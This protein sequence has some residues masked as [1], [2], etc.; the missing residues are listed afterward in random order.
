MNND[1]RVILW[2]RA[3][4]AVTW[5]DDRE[6][7]V[8]Q[9]TPEFLNSGIQLAPLMMPLAEFP[10]EF[11]ALARGTF[12]GL[13]GLLA[14]SLPDR[15]GNALID[16]WLA[17]QGR[18]PGS[19]HPVERLCYVGHRGMGALEFEPA[20]LGPPSSTS[21]IDLAN[22]VELVNRVLDER[23][24][25]SGVLAGE[26]DGKAMQDILRVGTSAGGAR[27]KAILAWNPETGEFR[28]GQIDAAAGFEHWLL[29]FD[30]ISNNRDKEL[31]DPKG[32]GKIEY[33]YHLMAVEAGIHM[34]P[35]R[36]LH[37][38]GRSHFMTKRFDRTADGGKRHLQSLGAIAHVDFNHAGA[39][40]YE[41]AIQVMRQLSLPREDLEQQVLRAVFNVV[42][43]NQDDHV[44][45][46]AFL[47]NRRG[48]WRLS[49]AFDITYAYN[50]AGAWTNRH[51][52]SIHGKWVDMDREDLIALAS[53]AGIKQA[54]ANEMI[55]RVIAVMR[56]WPDFALK[57]DVSDEHMAKVQAALR[58]NL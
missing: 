47:M 33:A 30:G 27:A 56:H 9:Y 35:C 5:L 40:S 7:A 37:E 32:Y 26:D 48:E 4:G 17:A 38:G 36:L 39:Y 41:Q 3:I 45:N 11:P 49:P 51:Q 52:M 18:A 6:V 28:S 54:R 23:S 29:K 25:L 12:R 22:L 21:T 34:M 55:D 31:A 16:A 20:V 42:G 2:G 43:R 44:K 46:I 1:A 58:T 53:A 8:F 14:D 24:S 19:F 57:A 15:F 10:Y 50:P 13:P